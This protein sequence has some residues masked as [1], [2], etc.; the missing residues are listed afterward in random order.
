VWDKITKKKLKTFK[1]S[2]AMIE[3]N[4]GA[5]LVKIKEESGLL[6]RLIV[7]SRS[8]PQLDLKECIGTYEFG[9]V[10]QSLFASDGTVLLAH[11]KAKILHHREL[12]VNNKQLVIHTPAI[13]TS[14]TNVSDNKTVQE[15]E[16]SEITYAPDVA[17]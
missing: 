7:I 6:Q 1:T 12:L 16:A 8:Q 17:T 11:D 2:N 5:K 14:T 3:V 13:K 9:I 15:M 4:V 10:T